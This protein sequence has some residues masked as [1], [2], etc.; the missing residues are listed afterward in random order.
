MEQTKQKQALLQL[1]MSDDL[2]ELQ[3]KSKHKF[4][5]SGH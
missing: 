5:I 4:N 2:A 3:A 1:L